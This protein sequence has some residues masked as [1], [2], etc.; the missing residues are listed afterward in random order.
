MELATLAHG[1]ST[2]G[3]LG[4]QVLLVAFHANMLLQPHTKPEPGAST[5]VQLPVEYVVLAQGFPAH[6]LVSEQLVAPLPAVLRPGPQG[7]QVRLLLA[8]PPKP[9]KSCAHSVQLLPS[10]PGVHTVQLAAVSPTVVKPRLQDVQLTLLAG[11]PG[12]NVA[13]LH[14]LHSSPP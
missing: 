1:D 2:Q 6:P 11:P 8:G 5:S 10:R 14:G 12:E 4:L 3:W 9:K 13:L 7:V